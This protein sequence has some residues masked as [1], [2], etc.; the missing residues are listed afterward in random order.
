MSN[1]R[2]SVKLATP[3]PTSKEQA[4]ASTYIA[5]ARRLYTTSTADL[6]IDDEPQVSIAEHGAWVSAWVWVTQEEA[7]LSKKRRACVANV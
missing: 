4:I 2:N 6:E 5:Q 7:G 3:K 1:D